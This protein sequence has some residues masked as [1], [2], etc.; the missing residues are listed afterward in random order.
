MRFIRKI[1]FMGI[2]LA[3]PVAIPCS[4]SSYRCGVIDSSFAAVRLRHALPTQVLAEREKWRAEQTASETVAKKL[5][6]TTAWSRSSFSPLATVD[7]LTRSLDSDGGEEMYWKR[8]SD[9]VKQMVNMPLADIGLVFPIGRLVLLGDHA[10]D[11]RLLGICKDVI[12]ERFAL[13]AERCSQG[14]QKAILKGLIQ[15]TLP[16]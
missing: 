11:R 9:F 8:V 6:T 14:L 7:V 15:Y 1:C 5:V 10:T 3:L 13:E 16:L 4:F 2:L 12:G